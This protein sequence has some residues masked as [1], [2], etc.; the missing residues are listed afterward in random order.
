MDW[1]VTLD[2]SKAQIF[3]TEYEWLGVGSVKAGFAINGQFITVHQFNH[4]NIIDKVYMT[5]A[6]LPLRYEIENIANTASSSSLKQ[7][8]AT[9]LS[10]GGYDRQP[11][12]WSAS[13]ATLFTNIGTTFVPLAAVRLVAGRTDSVVTISHLNIATTTNNLFEWA[14]LRNAAISGGTWVQNTPSQ[15]T[16]Y[17]VTATSLTNGTVVRRGYLAG[18]N[19][20]NAATDIEI[21]VGFDHQ[22]GRT[23]AEPPVS[24]IYCLAIR[25]ISGTGD[26]RGSLSSRCP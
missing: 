13:R 8:C 5:T 10:N 7:I 4:A 23:N 1:N 19:Q 6:T 3:F 18:S 12:V 21:P 26:A 9:V 16:E 14:L 15:D 20:N 11:E 2:L 17:N 24:E 22:I 25:T